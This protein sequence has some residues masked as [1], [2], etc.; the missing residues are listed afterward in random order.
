M[1]EE[2]KEEESTHLLIL[3]S[4]TRALIQA[5]TY[6][7]N[8]K[9]IVGSVTSIKESLAYIV[10]K[11]PQIILISADI[12]SKKITVLPKML[13]QA[14]PIKCIGFC[15]FNSGVSVRT[16]GELGLEYILY[17]PV[18][19]PA[20]ER[21]LLKMKKDEEAR[22][23]QANANPANSTGLS[24]DSNSGMIE[25]KGSPSADLNSDNLNNFINSDDS[26]SSQ[27]NQNQ[28]S[29]G[30]TGMAYT[31]SLGKE[32]EQTQS[33]PGY[34]PGAQGTNQDG[35]NGYQPFDQASKNSPG[36][37][38][39]QQDSDSNNQ[40]NTQ[41]G[42]GMGPGGYQPN[43]SG[44]GMGPGGYQPNQSGSGMGPGGY[45]PNQ[46]ASAQNNT[47]KTNESFEQWAERMRQAAG[48]VEDAAKNDS[49]N[50]GG[51]GSGS[52]TEQN[53]PASQ[54]KK[55]GYTMESEY[56]PKKKK[57][58][59]RFETDSKQD[60]SNEKLIVRGA[61]ISLDQTVKKSEDFDG[62]DVVQIEKASNI[63]CITI[64]SPKFSGYLVCALGKDRKMDQKFVQEV[65]SKLV[66]FLVD[67]GEPAQERDT[68]DMKI[69]EVDFTDWALQEAEF[70]RTSVH[71]GDEIAMAFFPTNDLEVKLED[72]ASE[73]MVKLN[74]DD[75]K[76]DAVVEFDLYIFMPGNNKY[77]LYTPQ[78]M[79]FYGNQKNRL[80]EKGVS[81]I[82][83]RKENALGV[84]KYKAQNFLNE[85]IEAYKLARKMKEAGQ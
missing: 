14:F 29:G 50:S 49:N 66:K 33:G 1:S 59:Y 55:P 11:N 23:A 8:R 76:E 70:L 77:L 25:I 43:Q 15:E 56:A 5:E 2:I 7:R 85:K 27:N 74:I 71:N 68:L 47:Q 13:A 6:L 3:K 39:N 60:L 58:A 21:I 63:A 31:G 42:S 12:P 65:Q 48:A 69:Q 37:N 75:L 62:D 79:P 80:K 81:H 17:P 72:S 44:S 46:S 73:K 38:P 40:Q 20:I 22:I 28:G 78:G 24:G 61:Q 45:Q 82:H 52:T 67:N 10:Q 18:S 30:S 4:E 36:Y 83:L 32:S 19:G 54:A 9:F 57:K 34:V 35:N 41:S 84:K 64:Q 51:S 16:L 26:A 53:Y